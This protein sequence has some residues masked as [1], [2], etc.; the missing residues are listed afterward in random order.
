MESVRRAHRR[1]AGGGRRFREP[2]VVGCNGGYPVSGKSRREVDGVQAP[3]ALRLYRGG[4]ME[5]GL[6]GR[7][8]GNPVENRLRPSQSLARSV[9]AAERSQHFHPGEGAGNPF[10]APGQ[11]AA[12][13]GGFPLGE[14]ELDDGR[15]V[16]VDHGG[17][18]DGGSEAIFA[19]PHQVLTHYVARHAFGGR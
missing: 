10:R 2:P 5:D 6:F 15:G 19:V 13:R 1:D 3:Q 11:F 17:G 18:P 9:C 12:K 4:G 7:H 16:Q 14:H 8:E